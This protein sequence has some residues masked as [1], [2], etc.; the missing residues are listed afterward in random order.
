MLQLSRPIEVANQRDQVREALMRVFK[1]HATLLTV[2]FANM[3][4]PTP[5]TTSSQRN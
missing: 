5:Q 3:M 4:L 2:P 1:R